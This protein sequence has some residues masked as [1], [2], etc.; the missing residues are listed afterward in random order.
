MKI[1]DLFA[2]GVDG[3]HATYYIACILGLF[4]YDPDLRVVF[5][6][7]KGIFNTKNKISTMLFNLVEELVDVGILIE[8]EKGQYQYNKNFDF[9]IE[10]KKR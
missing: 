8:D 6:E 7:Y 2:E 4:E 9:I 3:D 5:L 1:E 10:S